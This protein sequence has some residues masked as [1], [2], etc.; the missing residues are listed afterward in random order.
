MQAWVQQ[1]VQAQVLWVERWSETIWIKRREEA[2]YAQM[3][4]QLEMERQSRSGQGKK[5]ILKVIMSM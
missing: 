1:L 5:I 4:R 3:Q 2:E